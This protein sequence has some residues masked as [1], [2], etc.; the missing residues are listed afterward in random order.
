MSVY[1]SKNSI[2]NTFS[3][4]NIKTYNTIRKN[5][6]YIRTIILAFWQLITRL[7]ID[8]IYTHWKLIYFHKNII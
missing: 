7:F 6:F 2:S 8:T 3:S 5:T 4:I 1:F